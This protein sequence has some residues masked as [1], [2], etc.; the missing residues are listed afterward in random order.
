MGDSED[1]VGI[2][3]DANTPALSEDGQA[4]QAE[5][6]SR[7]VN[8]RPVQ[9]E[10]AHDWA[11]FDALLLRSCWEY[12]T[13]PAAFDAWLDTVESATTVL[14]PPP[15]VRWNMHKSYLTDLQD[16][17]VAILPTTVV[18][19][20]SE[21]R[22][23]DICRQVDWT[24]AV[25]KPAI[26]AGSAGV[27]RFPTADAKDYQERF[28]DQM[29]DGALLVQEYAP[30]IED[31]ELSLV[32]FRG[33]FSHAF[34]SVPEPDE[35]SSYDH[36]E[37]PN[38]FD[39]SDALI[40]QASEALER[41]SSLLGLESSELVYARVDGLERDGQFQLMELELIEPYLGLRR[42]E[43]ALD[44]F[45]DAIETALEED[46]SQGQS[47][48]GVGG[49]DSA[50]GMSQSERT[51]ATTTAQPETELPAIGLGTYDATGRDCREA[52]KTALSAGYRHIDTAEMYENE[53]AVGAGL[54]RSD[55]DREEVFVAS[56]IH[57]ANLGY[58]DVIEQARASCDRLGVETLDLL[59]VHWPIR[60]YEPAE[61]LAAFDNLVDWGIVRHVGLSNF[62]PALLDE[63]LDQLEAPL[64]A[65]QVECH[66]LLPQAELRRRAREDGHWLVAYSPI[67]RGG[68][69]EVP[70]LQE[71]A[72]AHDATPAQISL[73][74]LLSKETV[75][76][77]PK[78][79][80]PEHIRENFAARKISLSPEEIARIDAIER[81]ERVVDPDIAPW[82]Q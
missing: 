62:T 72:A 5:L 74:W 42:S 45:A 55:V 71:I 44:R 41:A 82:N 34:R 18:P 75:C 70:Q 69:L 43:G 40:E 21:Y 46:S 27:W 24:D 28:R 54:D 3:T 22:L 15:V 12:H 30:E 50:P 68:A 66:P 49:D 8:A 10:Q 53:S 23:E 65:H 26:G 6:S 9:W 63:A 61:T 78:S 60:A 35:F 48:G 17:G 80:T 76:V 20:G 13:Q 52:V 16:Q 59:Y 39:P 57:S 4:L 58:D 7:G 47:Q 2:V 37:E 36:D 67:A 1:V 25:V 32:F 79:T 14:N 81:Q 29:A 56:K 77:I 11:G 38:Q 73:A 33:S 31:G 64:C 51:A 19:Q